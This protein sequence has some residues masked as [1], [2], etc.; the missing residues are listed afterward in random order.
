MFQ[1]KNLY[2]KRILQMQK[3]HEEALEL[4]K[5]KNSDYGDSFAEYGVVGVLVRLGDKMKRVQNISTKGIELVDTES[6]RDT[7]IDLHNY[8]AMALMLLDEK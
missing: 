2:D 7:L 6:L 1:T 3:I 8:A 5:K 4:F